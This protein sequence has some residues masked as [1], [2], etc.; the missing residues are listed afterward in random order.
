MYLGHTAARRQ[1]SSYV[2][3]EPEDT[4][5]HRYCPVYIRRLLQHGRM[6]RQQPAQYNTAAGSG[7]NICHMDIFA[8]SGHKVQEHQKV[9]PQAQLQAMKNG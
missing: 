7:R 3:R 5:H 9:Y 8:L 6:A 2:Y 1:I 4:S